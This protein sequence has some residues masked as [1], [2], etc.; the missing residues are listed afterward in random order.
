MSKL[1]KITA[2]EVNCLIHAYFLDSGFSHSAFSLAS[3]AQ[4][5]LSP[6]FRPHS[7]GHNS[8]HTIGNAQGQTHIRRGTLISLLA[9]SLLYQ[10]VETH[11]ANGMLAN[12]CEDDFT[13][14]GEHRCT[15]MEKMSTT[16]IVGEGAVPVPMGKG[17]MVPSMTM[18]P[19]LALAEKAGAQ[20]G[21]AMEAAQTS[22]PPVD[23]TSTPT[24]G[25]A[26]G[27]EAKGGAAKRKADKVPEGG[28][29]KKQKTAAKPDPTP[30]PIPDPPP[31]D[32]DMEQTP[33][34]SPGPQPSTSI[35]RA[36]TST[37]QPLSTTS[38]LA[39]AAGLSAAPAPVAPTSQ[40]T[41]T[42]ATTATG[43]TTTTAGQST[44]KKPR[45]IKDDYDSH[46]AVT[47]LKGHR[48]EVFVA[49]WNPVVE[50]V[51]AT[52]CKD[53]TLIIWNV[54]RAAPSSKE[55][56]PPATR[57][58][59][60]KLSEAAEA[61]MTCIAWSRQGTLLATAC[62]DARVRVF[63]L[64]KSR[65]ADGRVSGIGV[66]KVWESAKHTDP[67]YTVSFSPNGEH[68][69]TGSLDRT[70]C[71]WGAEGGGLLREYTGHTDGCVDVEWLNDEFFATASFDKTVHIHSIRGITPI[72]IIDT[73]THPINQ[74]K[75]SPSGRLLGV[76]CDDQ[77]S[78]V[79]ALTSPSL[80][81]STSIF[82]ASPSSSTTLAARLAL[83]YPHNTPPVRSSTSSATLPADA[84]PATTA[85]SATPHAVLR[86]HTQAVS[87]IAWLPVPNAAQSYPP[88]HA[89]TYPT[90]STSSTSASSL[91]TMA[92]SVV[93][94]GSSACA[95]YGGRHDVLCSVSFDGGVVLWDA[96]KGEMMCRLEGHRK[97]C[98]GVDFS[99]CGRFLATGAGD[100]TLIVWSVDGENS[101]KVWQWFAG[102][103]KSGV[104]EIDWKAVD[105]HGSRLAIALERKD[106]GV[107]DTGRIEELA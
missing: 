73:H 102:S 35:S 15:G 10:E 43:Q 66:E 74:V 62:Y 65:G 18:G 6:F 70:V 93:A 55:L 29:T 11:F 72:A 82:T 90:S 75:L 7:T 59:T 56:P 51:L 47:L 12:G 95:S 100:G 53:S 80:Y 34:P 26:A 36:S 1:V 38:T 3:E 33:G 92:P 60:I 28:S 8:S 76:G 50:G 14:L 5:S 58:A 78:S 32:V 98:Y 37:S 67:V 30:M 106:V 41:A 86:G 88:Y 16:K 31:T 4:L 2:D 44:K 27:K 85:M 103:T 96:D 79:W 22:V 52:G 45:M 42:G 87:T 63:R 81:P 20:V 105:G 21:R 23:E 104:F 64:I 19:L 99:P 94:D 40:S 83:P 39:P 69:L 54:P 25:K 91:S 49:Q 17:G 97:A 13:L 84:S 71:L 77:T 68:M 46:P 89:L 48:A 24:T 61:D 9:K 57:L 107:I 101:K